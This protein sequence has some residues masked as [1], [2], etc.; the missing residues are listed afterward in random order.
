MASTITLQPRTDAPDPHA[1]AAIIARF[2]EETG[3]EGEDTPEG[4][5]IFDV[6]DDH[7]IEVVQTLDEIDPDWP[8]HIALEDP[9]AL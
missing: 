1:A 9:A 7:E 4:G 5:R 3:L 2:G 8:E 6:D